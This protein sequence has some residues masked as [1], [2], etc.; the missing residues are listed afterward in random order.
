MLFCLVI[1]YAS[2]VG[3]RHGWHN[4]RLPAGDAPAHQRRIRGDLAAPAA[5]AQKDSACSSARLM[6]SAP[7]LVGSSGLISPGALGLCQAVAA[8]RLLPYLR[9]SQARHKGLRLRDRSLHARNMTYRR[10]SASG[11][12]GRPGPAASATH[13]EGSSAA[14]DVNRDT[15]ARTVPDLAPLY[16]PGLMA[17]LWQ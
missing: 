5:K 6:H 7:V 14:A 2:Q 1:V 11:R 13:P 10:G 17:P 3:I 8:R 16:G 4:T 12:F 9:A 15:P